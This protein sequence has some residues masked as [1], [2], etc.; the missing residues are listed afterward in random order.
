[1]SHEARASEGKI[2]LSIVWIVEE[3][4]RDISELGMY[5]IEYL[6]DSRCSLGTLTEEVFI[7]R[8]AVKL[9]DSQ[10]CTFLPAVVLFL[11]EEVELV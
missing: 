7:A 3:S 4:L 8:L 9:N 11:H 5:G 2:A 6:L 10:P 1:V